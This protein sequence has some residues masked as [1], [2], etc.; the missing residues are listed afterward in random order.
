MNK[1]T[2]LKITCVTI[3]LFAGFMCQDCFADDALRKLGRG[4]T[5][6]VFGSAEI[7]AEIFRTKEKSEMEGGG[8]EGG[9]LVVGTLKGLFKAVVRTGVGVYEVATFLIPV[10]SRY[11]PVVEPEFLF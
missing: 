5:N 2:K 1:P 6:A 4:I 11:K 8:K 10:P 7:P 3:L 9:N